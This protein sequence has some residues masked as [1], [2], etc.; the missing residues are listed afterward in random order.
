MVTP[1]PAP[2]IETQVHNIPYVPRSQGTS[3]KTLIPANMAAA[4][5]VALQR[6]EQAHGNI[7]EFVSQRLGYDSKAAMWQVLYAEQVDSLALAFDQRDRG[8]IFLNG[9]QTGNGKGRF[10]AANLID[11]RRQGYIPIFVTR[12]PDLYNAMINEIGRASCRERV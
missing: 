12:Q 4:A 1:E 9:D 2:K 7:D 10:G 6:V 11:A 8:K 3:P 5:Q